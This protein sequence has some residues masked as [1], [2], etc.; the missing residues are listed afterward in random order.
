MS[1]EAGHP[2]PPGPPFE[3]GPAELERL[4]S[5]LRILALRTL[6]DAEAAEEAAQES[7][8]RVVGALREGR[9]RD[10][11]RLTAFARG[12]ARHVV[13]DVLRARMRHAP[14]AGEP[15]AAGADALAM[16]VSAEEGARIRGAL[17]MLAE[18]DRELLRLSFFDGLAPA[19]LARRL[20]EPPERIR[21]RKQRA[22]ERLRAAFLGPGHG[23]HAPP[24]PG[25]WEIGAPSR[26][27]TAPARE[28]GSP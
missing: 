18:P 28:E 11:G 12:I 15:I 2:S 23:R 24:T 10:P 19:E 1:I 20:G 7:V 5:G 25:Q 9:L 13:V 17:D 21:K 6:G 14:L 8:F 22:L 26:P 4:R 27:T 16:L 3:L